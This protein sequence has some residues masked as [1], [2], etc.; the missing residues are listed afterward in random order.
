MANPTERRSL[1]IGMLISL[2][3]HALVLVYRCPLAPA[4]PELPGDTERPGYE[5][6]FIPVVVEAVTSP[7]PVVEPPPQVEPPTPPEPPVVVP[8]PP[9][10][11][12]PPDPEPPA[13]EP[14]P[15]VAPVAPPPEPPPATPVPPAPPAPPAE[16]RV[17]PIPPPVQPRPPKPAVPT[18]PRTPAGGFSEARLQDPFR[19]RYPNLSRL[20]GEQGVVGLRI[21]VRPDGTAGTV[22]ILRSSGHVRLDETAVQAARKGRYV[23]ARRGGRPVAGHF[24]LNYRFELTA[25]GTGP[26]A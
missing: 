10:E 11:P 21:E 25:P 26:E 12:P 23:P 1:R 19:P 7:D 24:E 2:A 14:E 18:P 3:V 20:R 4:Q 13:Q 6:E 15:P 16:P 17:A 5:L 9:V 8:E 22:T